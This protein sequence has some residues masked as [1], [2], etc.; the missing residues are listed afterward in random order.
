MSQ[1]F[2]S[3]SSISR[4]QTTSMENVLSVTDQMN[5]HVDQLY[6]IAQSLSA[7]T[8]GVQEM[9]KQFKIEENE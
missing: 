6:L 9:V 7:M 4:D 1:A 2:E 8:G 3:V 5:E